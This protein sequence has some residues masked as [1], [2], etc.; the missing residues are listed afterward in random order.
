MIPSYEDL[1]VVAEEEE[2][3]SGERDNKE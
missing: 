3:Y 1:E 2:C